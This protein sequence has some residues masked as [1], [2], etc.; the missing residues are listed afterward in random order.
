MLLQVQYSPIARKKI[1]F[2]PV[3]HLPIHYR[4]VTYVDPERPNKRKP[5]TRS[6]S[7]AMADLRDR[8]DSGFNCY[9]FR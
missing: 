5:L 3:L 1:A 7:F 8:V 2:V 4:D 6:H 9:K